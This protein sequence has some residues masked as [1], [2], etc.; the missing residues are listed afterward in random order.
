[1]T[2]VRDS[3]RQRN[4]SGAAVA[5]VRLTVISGRHTVRASVRNQS[6]IANCR[7]NQLD[8]ELGL[9]PW[10]GRT[11]AQRGIEYETRGEELLDH[12]TVHVVNNARSLLRQGAVPAIGTV[13][14]G[15]LLLR[16]CEVSSHSTIQARH[17]VVS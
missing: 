17:R 12:D 3:P 13:M 14:R 11:R 8:C 4:D 1:M 5:P 10:I 2:R 16:P 7:V 6:E 9:G 15:K